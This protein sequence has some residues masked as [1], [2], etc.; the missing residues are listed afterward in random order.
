MK[1]LEYLAQ[2]FKVKDVELHTKIRTI[3]ERY[4]RTH[5]YFH[6][7]D[8]GSGEFLIPNTNQNRQ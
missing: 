5:N 7:K 6:T 8:A 1:D 2:K 4:E 3:N